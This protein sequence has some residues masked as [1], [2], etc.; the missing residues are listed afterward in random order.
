MG[1]LAYSTSPKGALTSTVQ[2]RK[3]YEELEAE[4]RVLQAENRILHNT[5]VAMALAPIAINL[6]R[7][8]GACVIA[9]F[10]YLSVAALAGK[11][12][13]SAIGINVLTNVTI[14]SALAWL[15][16]GGSVAYGWRERRLRKRTIKRLDRIPQLEAKIDP[17]RTSSKLGA[18]G[19]THPRDRD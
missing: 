18:G 13:I 12:T 6:V 10:G 9:G 19:V 4:N 8:A 7:W 2:P 16:A 5:N 14:N 3:T 11:T 17:G 1:S 15:L